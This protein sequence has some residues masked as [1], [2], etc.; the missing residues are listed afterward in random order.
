MPAC[1]FLLL[2]S[3]YYTCTEGNVLIAKRK[4]GWESLT[5]LS[6]RG[7]SITKMLNQQ[8]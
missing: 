2:I 6:I 5:M 1:T 8:K 7:D 3:T 4:R